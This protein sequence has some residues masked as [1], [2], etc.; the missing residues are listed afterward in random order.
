VSKIMRQLQ[1]EGRAAR[2]AAKGED[3]T[4]RGPS[5][6]IAELNQAPALGALEECPHGNDVGRV[7]FA[8]M[9][10][11]HPWAAKNGDQKIGKQVPLAG[12]YSPDVFIAYGMGPE[13][14]RAALYHVG[15][16]ITSERARELLD[17][18]RRKY[19]GI[20]SHW[21]SLS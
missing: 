15:V 16:P 21:E 19:P 3:K 20:R 17:E 7:C 18:F 5:I 1:E 8:C 6:A 14:L 9:L 13:R 4:T 10:N 12:G 2:E 11:G